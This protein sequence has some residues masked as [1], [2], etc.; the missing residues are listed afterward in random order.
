MRRTLVG[1]GEVGEISLSLFLSRE[2]GVGGGD[3]EICVVVAV[4]RCP[5]VSGWAQSTSAG[6]ACSGR[7]DSR[8]AW[9][10]AIR[11]EEAGASG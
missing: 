2:K 6:R 11:A 5:S 1:G 3:R 9:M 7:L 10:R 8:W 4:S